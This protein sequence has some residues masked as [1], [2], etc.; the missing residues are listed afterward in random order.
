[1]IKFKAKPAKNRRDWLKKQSCTTTVKDLERT[2]YSEDFFEL[3]L[4]VQPALK[5]SLKTYTPWGATLGFKQKLSQQPKE[6]LH[7][8]ALS[9]QPQ[10]FWW[11]SNPHHHPE[12]WWE[13]LNVQRSNW[14]CHLPPAH[15]RDGN[16]PAEASRGMGPR[17]QMEEH[18][19]TAW[20][21]LAWGVPVIIREPCVQYRGNRRSQTYTSSLPLDKAYLSK[22]SMVLK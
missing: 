14:K 16:A 18:C 11:R 5:S 17:A 4:T 7:Y 6:Q 3:S 9:R 19:A 8:K 12:A 20:T 21:T 15:T 1:M 22:V 2:I 10:E 13:A